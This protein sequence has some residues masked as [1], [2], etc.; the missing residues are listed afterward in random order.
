MV[1]VELA[2]NF[3][4]FKNFSDREIEEIAKYLE[5][6]VYSKGD[7]LFE[8]GDPG[9]NIFFIVKGRVD[10]YRPDAFGNPIKV[11]VSQEGTPLGELS[12]FS[13]HF[14]SS[15]A[16]AAKETHVLILTREGY[17]KLKKEDPQLAI[18]L[19]EELAKVISERLKEMNKKFV[20]TTCFIW[21][22][23]KK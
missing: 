23:P 5:Y 9:D 3:P 12:F 20:D 1:K 17:E 16:V 8:E 13:S 21:G 22:G 6:K 15:K 11:A 7:V 2:R 14:H 18:K 19:L 4:L 10:L